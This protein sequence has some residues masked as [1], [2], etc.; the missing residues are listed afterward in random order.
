MAERCCPDKAREEW[1]QKGGVH[2]VRV[3]G[4]VVV[5]GFISLSQLESRVTATTPDLKLDWSHR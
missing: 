4:R 1:S 5:E 2:E 3:L